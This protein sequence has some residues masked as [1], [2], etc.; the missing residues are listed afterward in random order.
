[1]SDKWTK[2]KNYLRRT[3]TRA[4]SLQGNVY[5]GSK[6]KNIENNN[7]VNNPY[8]P[9]ESLQQHFKG[10]TFIVQENRFHVHGMTRTISTESFNGYYSGGI[11][12]M[13]AWSSP[14]TTRKASEAFLF[15]TVIELP[16]ALDTEFDPS[17]PHGLNGDTVNL[18]KPP[19]I[20]TSEGDV[21]LL[22]KHIAK[23]LP[24]MRD[25]EIVLSFLAYIIQNPGKKIR[26]CP[27]L[28]GTPGNGKSTI[29]VIMESILGYEYCH[30]VKS[31]DL[32]TK[33]KVFNGWM[34]SKIFATLEEFSGD[35]VEIQETLLTWIGNARI[36]VE[37]KGVD[38]RTIKNCVNFIAYSN[39]DDAVRITQDDRRFSVL[40]TAQSQRDNLAEHGLTESYF[41][42][43]Y[44]WLN[45]PGAITSI[46]GYLMRYEIKISMNV[47]PISTSHH[48]AIEES[49]SNWQLDIEAAIESG[50]PGAR[51]GFVIPR[52]I[53][54]NVPKR[55]VDKFMAKLGYKKCKNRARI[56]GVFYR[57]IYTNNFL[58]A[59]L[60]GTELAR[61]ISENFNHA[62]GGVFLNQ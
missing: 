56:N 60:S 44:Q 41:N 45:T 32:G 12:D 23:L 36:N 6:Q 4:V 25:Q 19:E 1:M 35:R 52:L 59:Q 53:A 31:S 38:E 54:D 39:R 26:W 18:F 37:A 15:N 2:N 20:E 49:K 5:T 51:G 3:I 46:A 61:K 58:M 33:G 47:L 8:I 42:D 50:D 10:V 27:V 55:G 9:A 29:S 34:P 30:T 21:S 28:I 22:L 43:L 62:V 48:R 17:L 7:S 11:Y 24:D 14:K 13:D 16:K 40:Y 57:G